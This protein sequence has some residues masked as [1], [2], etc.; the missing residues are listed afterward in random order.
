M[1]N[2]V[3]HIC[4]YDKSVNIVV[5]HE[6]LL[7]ISALSLELVF[8]KRLLGTVLWQGKDGGWYTDMVI[9]VIR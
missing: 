5:N 1:D 7:S 4:I 6:I 9:Y 2:I 3:H 8:P